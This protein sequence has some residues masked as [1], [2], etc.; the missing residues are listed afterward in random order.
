MSGMVEDNVFS[1][2]D[3]HTCPFYLGT[4]HGSKAQKR[5]CVEP[6][7]AGPSIPMLAG[8]DLTDIHRLVGFQI[9]S[10]PDSHITFGI[11]FF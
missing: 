11:Y 10:K 6:F 2:G 4:F 1:P 8:V 9:I 3:V 5:D 7:R